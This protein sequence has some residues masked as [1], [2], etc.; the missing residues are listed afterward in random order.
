MK[1][2]N[3]LWQHPTGDTIKVPCCHLEVVQTSTVDIPVPT[4]IEITKKHDHDTVSGPFGDKHDVPCLHLD[5]SV[6]TETMKIP[7]YEVKPKHPEGDD[8]PVPIPCMHPLIPEAIDTTR[9]L[10]F[11]TDDAKYQAIATELVDKLRDKLHVRSVGRSS[12]PLLFFFR[13]AVNGNPSDSNDPFWS[14]YDPYLHAI[15]VTRNPN[16]IDYNYIRSVL[17]HELGHAIVGQSCVQVPNEGDPHST[18]KPSHLGEA[19]SEGWADFVTLALKQEG[20]GTPNLYAFGLDF[21]RRDPNVPKTKDIEYNIMCILWDLY[22]IS[23]SQ[24]RGRFVRPIPDDDPANTEATSFLFE[25]LYGVFSPSL[26]TL[27]AGPVIWDIDNYLSRLK[28]LY[29]DRSTVIDQVRALHLD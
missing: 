25:Q 9:H 10:V 18:K 19:M 21:E 26:D 13:E 20:R 4:K 7:I 23:T 24:T 15:Q 3:L 16:G 29:P 28:T 6:T 22:D 27:P 12:R 11:F 2:A 5:A 17:S 1:F 8:S 14:H